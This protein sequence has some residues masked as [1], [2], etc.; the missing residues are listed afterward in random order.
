MHVNLDENK[1][2]ANKKFLNMAGIAGG[3]AGVFGLGAYGKRVKDKKN[4][5]I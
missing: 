4:K 2:N 1:T 5:I 3:L